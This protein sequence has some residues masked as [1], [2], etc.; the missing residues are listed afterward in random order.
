[1]SL[2]ELP[3]DELLVEWDKLDDGGRDL[4]AIRALTLED[5]FYLLVRVCR[6][7]DMLHPW[8]YARCREVEADPDEKLDLWAREHYKSTIITFAGAI[9]EILKDPDIT[10]GIFAHTRGIAQKFM[11]QIMMELQ[12]NDTLKSAF[13]DILYRTPEKSSPRWSLDNGLL[14]KRSSNPKEATVEAWGLVDGQPTSAHYKLRIYDDVVTRESVT[15]PEQVKKTTEA[16]ELSDNLGMAGGRR[17]HVGT[18]YSFADTYQSIIDRGSLQERIYPATHDGTA[19]GD[20]VL[21]SAEEWEKKKVTQGEYT[22]ACQMLQNPLSG[23]QATFKV[24]WLTYYDIRPSILNVAVLCDPARSKKKDSDNT[25]FA[26][27]GIDAASNKYLL[28]GFR[29]KM[30]LS[31]RWDAMK[32]LR[33][34]WMS[35]PGVQLVKCGY[36]KFGAE[37]D[38]DYF[39]ERMK[40]EQNF[41]DIEELA[42]PR[43]GGGSKIDRVQ[44]LEPDFRMGR[45]KLPHGFDEKK[46]TRNQRTVIEAG[47]GFRVGRNIV[48]RDENGRA[49]DLTKDF[50][51]EF[52]LFPFGAKKDLVDVCSRIYDMELPAPIMVDEQSLEPDYAED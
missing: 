31:E 39:E 8:I 4:S 33:R 52:R 11:R 30:K 28:D 12:S 1:M 26:V 49:Y 27:V 25:A 44:R 3:L 24:E 22:I 34:R 5:R 50:M 16:W 17:W 10:I 15:T 19:N 47:E 6:R 21:L 2:H 48:R 46:V 7:H 36:E 18:R 43:E 23:Q 41:F 51:D 42:W 45:F 29:H 9:Q 13:P 20:P 37:S 35:M 14:V 32:L 38:F 40:I